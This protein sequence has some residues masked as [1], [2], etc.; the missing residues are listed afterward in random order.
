MGGDFRWSGHTTIRYRTPELDGSTP[1]T[2][3]N[4]AERSFKSLFS[5]HILNAQDDSKQT[6]TAISACAAHWMLQGGCGEEQGGMAPR[7]GTGHT[8]NYLLGRTQP[9][10]VCV[11]GVE[12]GQFYHSRP[13]GILL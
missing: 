4:S 6:V 3:L 7:Q 13:F 9:L 5:G 11:T 1:S 2:Q 12:I 8:L 10:W